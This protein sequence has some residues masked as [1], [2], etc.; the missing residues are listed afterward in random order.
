[1]SRVTT[2]DATGASV[3]AD[4]ITRLERRGVTVLLSG[5]RPQH[6]RVLRE[7][8]VHERLAHERHL[9]AHTP[10]AIAHA[11]LHASRIVHGPADATP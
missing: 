5:I 4:T 3:V 9:F 7:L 2:V 1:M 10:E 11:R 6:E 8:G